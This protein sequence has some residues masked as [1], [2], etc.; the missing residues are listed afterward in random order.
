MEQN[1][2]VGPIPGTIGQLKFLWEFSLWDV[3]VTGVIPIS[4]YNMTSL[5]VVQI[6][7][8]NLT[9]HIP[10]QI[11]LLPNIYWLSLEENLFIGTH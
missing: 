2:I 9:G 8:T 3:P 4:I 6:V 5:Q 11:G 7:N 10:S 1:A